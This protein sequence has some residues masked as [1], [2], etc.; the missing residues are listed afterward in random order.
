MLHRS[1]DRRVTDQID[2]LADIPSQGWFPKWFGGVIFPLAFA[3]YGISCF[4]TGHG[5]LTNRQMSLDLYGPNAAA[6]GGGS[7]S[8]GIFLHCH[9]FWGNIYQ[10]SFI[11]VLGKIVALMA[12][13][14]SIGYLI[15]RVGVLG[16]Q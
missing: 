16:R 3:V 10:M 5:V 6:L 7:L 4:V 1:P 13:I 11:A 12:F 9:Y 8:I 2:E 14:G 15:V